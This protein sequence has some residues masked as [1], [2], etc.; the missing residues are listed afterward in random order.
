MGHRNKEKIDY[1]KFRYIQSYRLPANQLEWTCFFDGRYLKVYL[2]EALSH[3]KIPYTIV[4]VCDGDDCYI[5]KEFE[6]HNNQAAMDL[7]N[8]ILNMEIIF[9]RNLYDLGMID[10]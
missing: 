3:K 5:R 2:S 7:L 4:G 6:G 1:S 9:R 8:K 10:D